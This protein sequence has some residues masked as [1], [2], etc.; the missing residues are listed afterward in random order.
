MFDLTLLNDYE[1]EHLC[2]DI[3]VKRLGIPLQTF[4]RGR[5]GGVDI[6]D[7][8][9]NLII[10][11][12]HYAKS[13]V[14]KLLTSL[15]AEK[16]KVEK[17]NPRNYVVC[18]SLYLT[19]NQKEQIFEM[20][21]PYMKDLDNVFS[22][23]NINQFLEEE[24]NISI[25]KKNFK[26]WL[27]A[28]NVL[29]LVYNQNVFIDCEMLMADIEN[30]FPLFVN[31]NAYTSAMEILVEKDILIITGDPGVG[32]ST[33]S[34]ML[35]LEF[36][37]N[38]YIVRYVDDNNLKDLKNTISL[39]PGKKE[40]L[41][42][43][44]FLGRNY[45]K[46][47][48]N[49]PN[50]LSTLVSIIERSKSKKLILNSRLV[51]LNEAKRKYDRI[52][53][54]VVSPKRGVYVL[55]INNMSLME[56]AKIL[57]NHLYFKNMRDDYYKAIV[58]DK[59][60]FD[61]IQHPN[62]NPRLIEYVTLSRVYES[63]EPNYYASY[64][65]QKLKNPEIVWDDEF[66]NRISEED[67]GLLFCIYSLSDI[68]NASLDQL[69]HSY[70]SRVLK[71]KDIDTTVN[72][73]K[74]SIARMSDSLIKISEVGYPKGIK[75][76]V[77]NPSLN[78]YLQA[79]INNNVPEQVCII[80][81]AKYCEQIDKVAISTEAKDFVYN[82]YIV[83]GKIFKLDTL[84]YSAF[85]YFVKF[86]VEWEVKDI[87]IKENFMMSF[88]R[89]NEQQAKKSNWK[90]GDLMKRVFSEGFYEFYKLHEYEL[91]PEMIRCIIHPMSLEDI[92]DFFI[93]V[94]DNI[95]NFV[96][97]DA[98]INLIIIFQEEY[99]ETLLNDV[100]EDLE[101]DEAMTVID[102]ILD[103]YDFDQNGD[104]LYE[105]SD[106]IE[107]EVWNIIKPLFVER[108]SLLISDLPDELKVDFPQF[109]LAEQR[110][111]MDLSWLI[112]ESVSILNSE[113]SS[114][115]PLKHEKEDTTNI[116]E[117]INMLFNRFQEH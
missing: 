29:S 36:A 16:E 21:S 56:K 39:D 9:K 46:I 98:L 60:Y 51:I 94:R 105:E 83:N 17:Q 3:M 45:L 37:I 77:V 15:R 99:L 116:K 106:I 13:G 19:L 23:D 22:G 115:T 107:E 96:K 47:Q 48:D 57:Y 75:V 114:F 111:D 84:E 38:D 82:S 71:N 92:V 59:F 27:N 30:D 40:I 117:E 33:L 25:V 90:Y 80:N 109:D 10:Q 103:G 79:E 69:Q 20:F 54:L 49:H 93:E 85:Y 66:K 88:T 62:Y 86:V 44:D 34:K 72:P 65:S 113:K 104:S 81:S 78:D 112:Q 41:F 43:D 97:D 42:L 6:C 91:S 55:D 26:L 100:R 102:S 68:T 31:T 108:I 11:V 18:T 74:Q 4:P 12:K 8:D 110:L 58:K 89:A 87:S 5:D 61:I 50:S 24:G 67:R 63:V 35:L 1:F 95:V 32:K 2:R 76:S 64:I 52:N 53:D 73:F 70:T 28:S 101:S 14:S 7:A